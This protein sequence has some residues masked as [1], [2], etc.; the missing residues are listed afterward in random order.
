MPVVPS[1]GVSVRVIAGDRC[2]CQ[3]TLVGLAGADGVVQIGKMSYETV[4][5]SKLIVIAM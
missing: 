5:M 2:G 4:S 1:V 3:G